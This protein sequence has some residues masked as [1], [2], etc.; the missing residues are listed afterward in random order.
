MQD[1]ILKLYAAAK[2]V[3]DRTEG[4]GMTEYAMAIGLIAFG[5][6]AGEAA[7]AT[8][9]N[10]IFVSIGTTIVNGVTH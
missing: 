1:L 8:S 2:F 6:I 5:C 3:L 7:V 4:Q 10:H 9:V